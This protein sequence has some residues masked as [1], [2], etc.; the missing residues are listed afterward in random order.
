MVADAYQDMVQ[1]ASPFVRDFAS[2][3]RR[4]YPLQIEA[5]FY[6]QLSKVSAPFELKPFTSP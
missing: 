6:S 5:L 2:I 3:G 4:L 1:K